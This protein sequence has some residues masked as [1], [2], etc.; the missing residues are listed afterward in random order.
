M[1]KI[2]LQLRWFAILILH[3]KFG[4]GSALSPIDDPTQFAKNGPNS[5]VFWGSTKFRRFS[6]NRNAVLVPDPSSLTIRILVRILLKIY[7]S[8][9]NETR[10]SSQYMRLN[11]SDS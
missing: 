5:M 6:T 9:T 11:L 2:G 1:V 3:R 7:L 10:I 4:F 8:P